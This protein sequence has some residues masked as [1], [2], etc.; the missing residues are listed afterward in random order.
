MPLI[1]LEVWRWGLGVETLSSHI[2]EEESYYIT[3]SLFSSGS[4]LSRVQYLQTT[5]WEK[6]NIAVSWPVLHRKQNTK[7]TSRRQ[8]FLL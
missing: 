3:K 5:G 7:K 1:W 4:L 6:E 8:L 2:E